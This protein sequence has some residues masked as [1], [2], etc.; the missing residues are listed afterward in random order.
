MLS[1]N[2]SWAALSRESEESDEEPEEEES[3]ESDEEPEEEESEEYDEEPE[4][5]ESEESDESDEEPEESVEV[6]T[7]GLRQR[8]RGRGR[9]T[10]DDEDSSPLE[11]STFPLSPSSSSSFFLSFL[12]LLPSALPS[13][14]S[15]QISTIFSA[16]S[17]S[18]CMGRVRC[19]RKVL[20]NASVKNIRTLTKIST[21]V[22][23]LL[24]A[25]VK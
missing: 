5:E 23:I 9:M 17:E 4:E 24:N 11:E 25:S 14:P 16:P 2:Y 8:R 12:L 3:E 1:R 20:L 13:S 18:V 19:K 7:Y 22:K 15:T 21:K 6:N 10:D